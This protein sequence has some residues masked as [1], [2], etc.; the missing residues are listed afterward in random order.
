MSTVC[1][2][3]L[4]VLRCCCWAHSVCACCDAS[5]KYMADMITGKKTDSHQRSTAF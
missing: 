5:R 3:A 2:S 4:S 1:C